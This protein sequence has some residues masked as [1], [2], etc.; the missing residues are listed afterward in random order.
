MW[1]IE[2]LKEGQEVFLKR[3]VQIYAK[4]I[5]LCESDLG[6]PAGQVRFA[7]ELLP[8]EQYYLPEDLEFAQFLQPKKSRENDIIPEP[9]EHLAQFNEVTPNI[10]GGDP[11]F[12][13]AQEVDRLITDRAY[14]LYVSGGFAQGHDTENWLQAESEILLHVPAEITE[15]ETQLI[16]RAEVPGFTEKNLEVRVAPRSICITGNRQDFSQETEETSA[17]S[18]RRANRIFRVLDLPSEIDPVRVDASLG[19]GK[20]EVKLFKVGLRKLVHVRAKSASA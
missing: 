15:T 16:I 13:L 7:V 9:V 20:L 4:V 6:L 12:D 8:L 19:D 2:P 5:G 10:S 1:N 11:F 18:E 14:E 3:P 17:S